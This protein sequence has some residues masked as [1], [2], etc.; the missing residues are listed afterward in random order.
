MKGT[1]SQA[2]WELA[3]AI[4]PG[5]VTTYGIIA[6]KAGGGGQAARSVTSILTKAPNQNAIPYHRIVYANGRAWITDACEKERRKLFKKEGI[7]IDE[8]GFIK[9]FEEVL[10][11]FD[12]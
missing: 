4:P 10:Y 8:R 9:D 11:R 6:K 2:V 12:E 5:R 1:F 3:T 7:E